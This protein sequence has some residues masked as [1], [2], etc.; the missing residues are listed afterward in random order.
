MEYTRSDLN[1]PSSQRDNI[2]QF[3]HIHIHMAD[4]DSANFMGY[5]TNIVFVIPQQK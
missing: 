3:L 2:K 1:A 5:S 4:T